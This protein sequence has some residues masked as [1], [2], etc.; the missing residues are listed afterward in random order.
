[1][2]APTFRPCDIC[3]GEGM[4]EAENGELVDCHLCE[5]AGYFGADGFPISRDEIEGSEELPN[6]VWRHAATPFADNH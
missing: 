5:G 2:T 1:M 3:D 6:C 4:E